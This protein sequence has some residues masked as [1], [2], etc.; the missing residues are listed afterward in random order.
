MK[1]FG[2]YVRTLESLYLGTVRRGRGEGLPDGVRA[3]LDG[4]AGRELRQLVPVE[5]LR[6]A[7]AFFTG[8]ELASRASARLI[9]SVTM[10]SRIL[11]PACGA[12][13]LLVACAK[14]LP[15]GRGLRGTLAGWGRCLMGRD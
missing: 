10:K 1:A 2:R 12:G 7:G 11:D 4:E 9:P 15:N 5:E 13:D 6:A 14:H 3:A 8:P